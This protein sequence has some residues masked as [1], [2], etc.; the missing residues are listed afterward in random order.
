MDKEGIYNVNLLK[1][2]STY[3]ILRNIFLKVLLNQLK[4]E[5]PVTLHLQRDP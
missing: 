2:K 5:F 4:T 3:F 1:N